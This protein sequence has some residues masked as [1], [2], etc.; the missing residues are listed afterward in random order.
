[1][2]PSKFNDAVFF[3]IMTFSRASRLFWKICCF[4]VVSRH[5]VS[6]HCYADD[7]QLY[8][9]ME[10]A[11]SAAS[12]SSP[13]PASLITCLEETNEWMSHNFLQLN[14]SRI[15]VTLVGTPH[16]VRLVPV[17]SVTCCYLSSLFCLMWF[18]K[19]HTTWNESQFVLV[20]VS[21]V[22]VK[23]QRWTAG[24]HSQPGFASCACLSIG[25]CFYTQ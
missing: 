23:E 6:F 22:R 15:E 8:I 24:F 19:G 9:R 10:Q 16:Q 21:C 14:S 20:C 25:F 5:G 3:R 11:S 4:C 13:L 7:T 18:K 2:W 17:N 1:M 12:S